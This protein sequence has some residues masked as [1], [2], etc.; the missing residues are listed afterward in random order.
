MNSDADLNSLQLVHIY[1]RE[2][3]RSRP[4]HTVTM[5]I[6]GKKQLVHWTSRVVDRVAVLGYGNQDDYDVSMSIIRS[7]K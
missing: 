2:Q 5:N 6:L 7:V 3:L 1:P 4:F